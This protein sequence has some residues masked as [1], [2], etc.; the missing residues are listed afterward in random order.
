MS[1]ESIF[2][3]KNDITEI[4][5]KKTI[6]TNRLFFL[7]SSFYIDLRGCFD[8]VNGISTPYATFNAEI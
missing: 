8:L 3:Y 4:M 2:T 7:C 5:I 6:K 1:V